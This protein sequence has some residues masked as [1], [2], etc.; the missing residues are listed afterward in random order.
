MLEIQVCFLQT[1][2]PSLPFSLHTDGLPSTCT[3]NY[4]AALGIVYVL[5]HPPIHTPAIISLYVYSSCSPRS[6]LNY[7]L[8]SLCL[9]S[10]LFCY[11]CPLLLFNVL[12]HIHYPRGM[13]TPCQCNGSSIPSNYDGQFSAM[14]LNSVYV[15][16]D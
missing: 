12:T 16:L 9:T 13:K 2:I 6:R 14:N 1:F 10:S 5:P 11:L 8:P 3:F 15:L 4:N 7:S